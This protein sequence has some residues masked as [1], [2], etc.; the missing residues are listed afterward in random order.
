[1]TM[2]RPAA[3]ADDTRPQPA[4]LAALMPFPARYGPASAPGRKSVRR[5]GRC[6]D[7]VEA[8]AGL[9]SNSPV[10]RY[11]IRRPDGNRGAV[12]MLGAPVETVVLVHAT[13]GCTA[14]ELP[15]AR[16]PAVPP[17][18]RTLGLRLL[19]TL[20]AAAAAAGIVLIAVIS[21]ELAHDLCTRAAGD[22]SGARRTLRLGRAKLG[23]LGAAPRSPRPLTLYPAPRPASPGVS[24]ST[25]AT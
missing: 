15:P 16:Q 24:I 25:L 10:D 23:A 2:H 13:I 1:M 14:D 19:R 8:G 6:P 11:P 12:K 22:R 20:A 7:L 3:P 18:L 4:G 17:R 9:R 21:A 5:A